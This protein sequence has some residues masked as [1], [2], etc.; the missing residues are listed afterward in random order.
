MY[1]IIDKNGN[2]YEYES[3]DYAEKDI[4]MLIKEISRIQ[5]RKIIITKEINYK[6][7]LVNT[8]LKE[9]T[10]SITFL[11]LDKSDG[12]TTLFYYNY[13]QESIDISLNNLNNLDLKIKEF[14]NFINDLHFRIN[15]LKKIH[16]SKLKSTHICPKC[17]RTNRI[18][19]Y[20]NG[21]DTT[22]QCQH[23]SE[24]YNR[25]LIVNVVNIIDE[26][27][28]NT[29]SNYMRYELQK[30]LFDFS[31]C[32]SNPKYYPIATFYFPIAAN[33]FGIYIVLCDKCKKYSI[34]LVPENLSNKR[35]TENHIYKITEKYDYITN[36]GN[37]EQRRNKYYVRNNHK[38][39]PTALLG[40]ID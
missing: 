40:I 7:P 10:S 29:L 34:I 15:N 5:R 33:I 8:L 12:E 24:I 38:V 35:D 2:S 18:K 3:I 17:F 30:T 21:D 23:C 28:F 32:C 14:E 39:I 19:K 11:E 26:R 6:N 31:T 36:C 37:H 4:A 1:Y 20:D 9:I 27:D 16:L 22:Y 25:D 13:G